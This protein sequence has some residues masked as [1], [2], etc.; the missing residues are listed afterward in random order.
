MRRFAHGK[1]L[2]KGP[3]RSDGSSRREDGGVPSREA[4]RATDAGGALPLE[5][6]E[7]HHAPAAMVRRDGLSGWSNRDGWVFDNWPSGH[8]LQVRRSPTRRDLS[9]ATRPHEPRKKSF[10]VER[11]NRV[12]HAVP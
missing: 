6:R 12:L 8:Q 5:A 3:D 1:G 7:P 4:V 9:P 11:R 10:Y 2:G